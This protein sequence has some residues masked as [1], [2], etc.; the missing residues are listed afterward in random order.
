MVDAMVQTLHV[1][2]IS[3]YLM[4]LHP[5]ALARAANQGNA[6]V[7]NLET[8]YFDIVF[9][10][11]GTP[12][13]IHT[14]NPRSEGLTLE[15]NIRRLADEISKTAAF[16]QSSQPQHQPNPAIP[17]LLT[18]DLAAET[19]AVELLQAQVDYPIQPLMPQIEFPPDFPVASYAANIGLALKKTPPK[20]GA[21]EGTYY[22]DINI[23]I[24]SG[25]YRKHRARPLPFRSI[26]IGAIP[27]IAVVCLFPLSQ[28]RAQLTADNTRLDSE[29]LDVSRQLNLA[30]II[31]DEAS[32]K[33]EIIK[34]ITASANTL[35]ATNSSILSTRGDYTYDLER[36]TRNMPPNT[37]F[38]TV[39][40][41]ND[42]I[43][44]QGEADS[45][46]AVVDYATAL[47]TRETFSEVRINSLVEGSSMSDSSE[48]ETP[49]QESGIIIFDILI[50]K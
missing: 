41:D 23:N 35:K 1:A 40:I 38:T 26:L 45:V 18:G 5:L 19:A 50:T 14:V 16:Y 39:E 17:L 49:P 48:V 10:A 24:L 6:I 2:G 37:I 21:G 42:V 8:N 13:V 20:P 28:A 34:E 9:I 4:D 47:E 36:V 29:L 11:D 33:E 46:F 44:I 22:H 3:P 30:N 15:D 32:Q 43:S 27:V 31:A 25:K 12:A 7:V